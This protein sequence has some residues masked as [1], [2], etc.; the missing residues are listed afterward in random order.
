MSRQVEQ[1][2][3]TFIGIME[4]IK[5]TKSFLWEQHKVAEDR[6]KANLKLEAVIKQLSTFKRPPTSVKKPLRSEKKH[7]K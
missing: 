1:T 3:K 6:E 4:R 2:Q 5:S 7:T